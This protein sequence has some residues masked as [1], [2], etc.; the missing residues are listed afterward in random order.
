MVRPLDDR[1]R[2][3]PSPLEDLREEFLAHCEARNL[4]GK[5]IAAEAAPR[6]G[7]GGSP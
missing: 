2:G 4:S 6:G 3:G 5:T 7:D 1:W